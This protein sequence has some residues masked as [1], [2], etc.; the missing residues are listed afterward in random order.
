MLLLGHTI[1]ILCGMVVVLLLDV[2]HR[3]KFLNLR[4]IC[5]ASKK[6]VNRE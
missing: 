4:F 2:F 1:K 5:V 3:S 6:G